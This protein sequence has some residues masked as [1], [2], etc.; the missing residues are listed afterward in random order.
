[1]ELFGPTY[2]VGSIQAHVGGQT[3][4]AC[5]AM[6]ASAFA[7]GNHVAFAQSPDLHTAAHEAAHVVQQARGV[8][9]YGGVGAAGDV[10][11]RHADAVADRVVAG[12]SAADL[13]AAGPSGSGASSAV[14]RDEKP[15]ATDPVAPVDPTAAASDAVVTTGFVDYNV[16]GGK[17]KGLPERKGDDQMIVDQ[18]KIDSNNRG[19]KDK[20]V[21]LHG[22]NA[23]PA[24]RVYLGQANIPKGS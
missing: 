8:N 24:G 6:G 7:T 13:L 3:A 15:K 14:Q 16:P 4:A 5:D 17:T 1:Q 11:E 23:A 22:G 12:Q 2:D 19:P 21:I 20:P 18:L 10:Y 9:L